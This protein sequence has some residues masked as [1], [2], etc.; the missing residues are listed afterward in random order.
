MM[1]GGWLRWLVII[2]GCTDDRGA[3]KTAGPLQDR[4]QGKHAGLYNDELVG[5]VRF[6]LFW[7]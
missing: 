7:Y 2:G 5:L 3:S 1:E 6:G 4:L